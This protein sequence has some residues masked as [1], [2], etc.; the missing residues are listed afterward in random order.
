MLLW[1]TRWLFPQAF[2]TSSRLTE[3]RE[4]SPWVKAP[5]EPPDLLQ[6]VFLAHPLVH[7]PPGIKSALVSLRQAP[8]FI[9]IPWPGG[10][11]GVTLG[12]R[13]VAKP[14]G[15]DTD[16]DEVYGAEGWGWRLTGMGKE[17]SQSSLTKLKEKCVGW[18]P[19]TRQRD[20]RMQ[21]PDGAAVC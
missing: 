12:E 15:G 2:R 6:F 1:T 17:D 18:G 8:Q 9:A 13:S 20:W 19:H 7:P 14:T 16:G 21:R 11:C 5:A 10:V 4:R 3:D